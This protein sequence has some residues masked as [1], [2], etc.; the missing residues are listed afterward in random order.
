M[1]LDEWPSGDTAVGQKIGSFRIESLLGAGSQAIVYRGTNEKT[2]DAVA[3]KIAR[4]GRESFQQRL[5]HSG[6]ILHDLHHENIVRFQA[7]GR[8]HEAAYLATEFV[9]GQTLANVLRQRG[10]LPWREAAGL[11]VQI[12]AALSYLHDRDFLHRNLKP[13]HLILNDGGGLKLI[14]FGLASSCDAKDIVR[15][16]LAIGTPGYMAPEQIC[17]IRKVDYRIDLYALGAVLWTLLTGFTPYQ[18]VSKSA[19]RRA[20]AALAFVQLTQPPPRP[21][22][23]VEAIPA[24][25]D[26]LVVQLMDHVPQKRPRDAASVAKVLAAVGSG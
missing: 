15:S 13:A 8:F 19:G 4:A 1:M 20:G 25:I 12:C 24:D 2:G 17:G 11:G 18:E 26:D 3:I 22:E 5:W 6:E 9:P 10:A 21:S 16:G 14:G 23:E 7:M